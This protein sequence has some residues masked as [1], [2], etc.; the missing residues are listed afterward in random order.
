MK[1]NLKLTFNDQPQGVN[2]KYIVYKTTNKVNNYIYI[3]VH[4]TKTP[5]A[6]DC[7]L[8]CGVYINKPTSY[9]KAKTAFQQAVKQFG[10]KNFYRETLAIFDTEE[11]AYALEEM[12]VNEQ[13]LAR[14]DVYNTILGGRI[15]HSEGK[16]VYMYSANNG[17]FIKKYKSLQQAAQDIDCDAS[18]ISHSI[19]FLFKIKEYCFSYSFVE[20]LDLS[21]YNFKNI[22]PIYRYLKTGE[23]DTEFPSA[24]AAGLNSLQ[25]STVYIQKAAT[26]GYLVK[27]TYYFSYYKETSY[28][29]ARSKAIKNRPVYKYD[30]EGVFIK[31][32]ETQQQA[33]LENPY[34]NITN[35]IKFRTK[36]INNCYWALEWLRI[37]NKPIKRT[38]KKVGLLDDKGNIIK[39]WESSNKCAAEVGVA[40]K[41][42]LTGKYTHHKGQVYKYI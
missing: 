21:I 33:E 12:L 9:E 14:A 34:C 8:G 7:Y 28:D 36:D 11:E 2:M 39:I 37:Y 42:V 10:P 38:S 5:E 35:S 3:G 40:V 26:L 20:S 16:E 25:T 23:Y 27:D 31:G 1:D 32:Y 17:N 24:N 29:K 15:N 22:V 41:N 30:S 6:F 4:K 18:T 19:K 13:F